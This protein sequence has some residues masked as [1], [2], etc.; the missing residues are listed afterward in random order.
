MLRKMCHL[1]EVSPDD[2]SPITFKENGRGANAHFSVRTFSPLPSVS[3]IWKKKYVKEL[4]EPEATIK[5]TSPWLLAK[6]SFRITSR[7]I[8][9]NVTEHVTLF[10]CLKQLCDSLPVQ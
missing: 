3:R 10:I 8:N 1:Q 5:L 2:K 6:Q 7:L 9:A 4:K